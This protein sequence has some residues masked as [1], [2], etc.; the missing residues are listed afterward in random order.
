LFLGIEWMR[1]KMS[2]GGLALV[3]SSPN[4]FDGFYW[5]SADS[6]RIKFKNQTESLFTNLIF[7]K[8]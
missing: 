4:K 3:G 1:E 5:N 7:E 2:K 8:S 6:V